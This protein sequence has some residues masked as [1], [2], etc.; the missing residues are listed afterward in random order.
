MA[1]ELTFGE[2]R[3]GWGRTKSSSEEEDLGYVG[4]LGGR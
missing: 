4:I 1:N 3:G 2:G